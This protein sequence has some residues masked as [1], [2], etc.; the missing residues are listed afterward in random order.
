M[1]VAVLNLR[2][3]KIRINI[4]KQATPYLWKPSTSELGTEGSP[5]TLRGSC[6]RPKNEDPDQ[7][8]HG[9]LPLLFEDGLPVL[10][11][12]EKIAKPLL[13]AVKS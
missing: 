3:K 1:V 11:K 10:S 6:G 4:K 13:G 5:S 9:G 8:R 7:H 2:A 12:L